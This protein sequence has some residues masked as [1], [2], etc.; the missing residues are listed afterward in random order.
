[1]REGGEEIRR[2]HQRFV[3]GGRRVAEA[4]AELGGKPLRGR[5]QRAALAH[6]R[7]VALDELACLRHHR[8]EARYHRR[9]QIDDAHAVRADQSEAEPPA[10]I[11]QRLLPRLA[12]VVA[13][14]GET[15]RPGDT[16]PDAGSNAI[17]HRLRD[18]RRRQRDDRK[19]GRMRQRVSSG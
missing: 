7:D 2:R 19:I 4:V 6:H 3:A 11:D 9:V 5:Y 15:T 1:M 16:R 14:L 10:G 8:G 13:L 12:F 17:L 18:R